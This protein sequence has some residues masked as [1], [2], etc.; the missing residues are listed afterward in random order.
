M[1][2]LGILATCSFMVLAACGSSEEQEQQ[3]Q[4]DF[5]AFDIPTL[6]KIVADGEPVQAI[7]IIR[8]KEQ[9]N[10]AT[11]EDFLLSTEIYIT[12][13]NGVAAEVE[14][15]KAV[16][17]GAEGEQ[18]DLFRARVLLLQKKLEEAEEF[19]AETT[20]T[21]DLAYEALLLR[22]DIKNELREY[23]AARGFYQ[24]AVD[25]KPDNYY[26]YV[27][28]AQLEL[29]QGF[30]E[31]AFANASRAN[32][33]QPDDPIVL[34]LLGST[35][36]YLLK[37]DEA[38]AYL[39]RA[40]ELNG[41]H[42]LALLELAAIYIEKNE[43]EEARKQLDEVY[44]LSPED[45][46]ARYYSALLLASEGKNEEAEELMLRLGDLPK[47][48]PPAARVYGHIAYRL[49]KYSTATPYLEQF[50][51]LLPEDRPTRLALAESYTR[52]GKAK[53][54]LR[55][56][57]VLLDANEADLEANLQAAAAAGIMG[58]RQK[59]GE[60]VTRAQNLAQNGSVDDQELIRSLGRRLA[61]NNFQKGNDKVAIDQLEAMAAEDDKDLLT[62][63]LMANLQM[64]TGD[65]E[66]AE[67][68]TS[69]LLAAAP[70]SPVGANLMG[71]IRYR[72]RKVDEAL[73]LYNKA[74]EQN[75][76]YVSALKN[77]AL[78]YL[79]Q[80]KF[81]EAREDLAKVV[82]ANPRDAQA[83]GMFG[84]ALLETGDAKESLGHFQAAEEAFPRSA[85]LHADHS[86]ALAKLGYYSTAIKRAERAISYSGGHE[87]L[88]EYLNNLIAEWTEIDKK[89]REEEAKAREERK[90]KRAE[91]R[92]ERQERL[93]E[94]QKEEE[95]T[96]EGDDEPPADEPPLH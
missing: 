53:E 94:G 71:S 47:I 3:Q 30:I 15:G 78:V 48:Y 45:R 26:G 10:L 33:L 87:K 80:E 66:S 36:R 35:S 6:E 13:L 96:D 64:E 69:R 72:Q 23:E 76:E 54:A 42:Y 75:S 25:D 51:R 86:E 7:Q 77:R 16:E 95:T 41:Q 22:G 82:A 92:K 93:K 8:G 19:L 17:L 43:F 58:D 56:L 18:V 11:I 4:I 21:N 27:G 52:R 20:F 60:Y 2:K 84:R 85:I 62:L 79:V 73:E 29:N 32:E 44:A 14:L 61:I 88:N 24:A 49:G 38:I 70:D 89:Q 65:L 39:K 81:Q 46:M 74:I 31:D 55:L 37:P 28:L 90:A 68:T 1:K 34:Y 91:Q 12:L 83:R 63:T 59:V 40:L 50:L 67:K 57:K 5:S 9:L